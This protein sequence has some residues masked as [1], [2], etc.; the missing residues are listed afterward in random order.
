[1][2]SFLLTPNAN[3]I[4][5]KRDDP[6]KMT[7]SGII[8]PESTKE[9]PK[10]GTIVAVGSTVAYGLKVGDHVVFGSYAGS[11]IKV[12]DEDFLILNDIDVLGTLLTVPDAA[13]PIV[14]PTIEP[15]V[16]A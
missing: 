2:P 3:R 1:M 8:L 12:G 6:V 9:K 16:I 14:E 13:V 4:S 7:E 5:V 15:A 10:T 11:E